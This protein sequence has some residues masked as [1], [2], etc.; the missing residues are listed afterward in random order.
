MLG[1]TKKAMKNLT[2]WDIQFIKLSCFFLGFFAA[3]F[4]SESFLYSY[5]WL[6]LALTIIFAIKPMYAALARKK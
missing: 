1:V 3:A 5:R 2:V 6:W 4:F